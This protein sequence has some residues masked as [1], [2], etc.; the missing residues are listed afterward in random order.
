[1]INVKVFNK[2]DNP[3]PKYMTEGA[4]GMD[5]YSAETVELKP[6]TT[7]IVGTG[8]F[9]AIPEGYELQ[10]RSRSGLAAKN[11]VFV[12]NGVGTIDSDF[13]GEIKV[14]LRNLS[15]QVLD[16]NVGD[17][18]AQAVLSEVPKIEWVSVNTLSYLSETSRGDGGLGSTKV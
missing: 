4:S 5:L 12:L 16:I 13:R 3:L 18:I 2:S 17:R 14:I 7:A 15:L 9:V 8:L 6:N 11:A 10:I 1:M